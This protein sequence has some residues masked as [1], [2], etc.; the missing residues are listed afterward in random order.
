MHKK[1]IKPEEF[2]NKKRGFYA[3][4]NGGIQI[5]FMRAGQIIKNCC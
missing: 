4:G 1:F 2:A 5:Q 3:M